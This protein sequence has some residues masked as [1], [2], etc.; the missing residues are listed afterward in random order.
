MSTGF[1][2]FLPFFSLSAALVSAQRSLKR[3]AAQSA[4]PMEVFMRIVNCTPHV[5]S[6]SAA[7][8]PAGAQLFAN[9]D[10][11]P[12]TAQDGVFSIPAAEFLGR[13]AVL[14]AAPHEQVLKNVRA[15]GGSQIMLVQTQFSAQP[16]AWRLLEQ[17]ERTAQRLHGAPWVIIGSVI[18]AQAFPGRVCSMIAAP[19]F[20]H[21]M[22]PVKCMRLDKFN[23]FSP[24]E[25]RKENK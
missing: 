14:S 1:W 3:S 19:G 24:T 16:E 6:F 9:F 22:T 17:I 8:L 23:M 15:D 21:G 7:T 13:P 18:A 5:C 25:G 10:E 2:F 11:A 12:L 20:E 4:A